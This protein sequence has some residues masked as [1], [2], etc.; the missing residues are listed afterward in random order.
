MDCLT[1]PLEQMPPEEEKWYCPMCPTRD[2]SEAGYFPPFPSEFPVREG[3]VASSS[4]APRAV[5][6]KSKKGKGRAAATDESEVD[7]E[8]TM[9]PRQST[10]VKS[11]R[12]GKTALD[13]ELE[14]DEVAPADQG[15]PH[16]R[17]R[18]RLSSPVPLPPM[19][20]PTIRL[21]LPPRGKG[22]DRE[23][24]GLRCERI[25]LR[26]LGILGRVQNRCLRYLVRQYW[27]LNTERSALR[28]SKRD[29][30]DLSRVATRT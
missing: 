18:L 19:K 30:L 21:R 27:N 24:G 4:R 12:S 22:K 8:V 26:A 23:V 29:S 28:L 10:R 16:K 25:A 17:P 7:T 5:N 1:P 9:S 6:G 20:P 15:R 11:R 14:V 3:S 2:T 13:N